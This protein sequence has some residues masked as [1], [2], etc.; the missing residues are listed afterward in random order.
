MNGL[1]TR[2]RPSVSI[3]STAQHVNGLVNWVGRVWVAAHVILVFIGEA[4]SFSMLHADKES[5]HFP[6]ENLKK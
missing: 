3:T 4:E 1:I 2:D 5:A 6:A